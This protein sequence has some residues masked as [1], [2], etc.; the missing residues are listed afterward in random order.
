MLVL[1]FQE[2]NSSDANNMIQAKQS[3]PLDSSSVFKMEQPLQFPLDSK[4]GYIQLG[5]E[6]SCS[7]MFLLNLT[8][9]RALELDFVMT[10]FSLALTVEQLKV[11]IMIDS[12]TDEIYYLFQLLGNQLKYLSGHHSKKPF[13][14]SFSLMG[15]TI[16]TEEFGEENWEK[17]CNVNEQVV[18][19]ICSS[20]SMLNSYLQSNPCASVCFL[21]SG[22]EVAASEL[23]IQVYLI[24]LL[25]MIACASLYQ[26]Y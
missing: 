16:K 20:L 5:P 7:D 15:Q 23:H 11:L 10:I 25:V 13:Q 21:F 1:F 12:W 9:K 4:P 22:Q 8:V 6:K 3:I 2:S 17:A 24:A 18:L 26:K 19:P 14:V